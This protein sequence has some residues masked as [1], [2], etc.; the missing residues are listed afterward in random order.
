MAKTAMVT[1]ASGGIGLEFAERLAKEGYQ[2]TLVARG[3]GKLKEIVA[4]LGAGHR[5]IAADL[6]VAADTRRVA[7]DVRA[8]KYDL[9]VNN[10]GVGVYGWF[11]DVPVEPT[12]AMMRLN[13][14]SLV[15]LSHTFLQGAKSGDALL[16]VAST[17]AL[18]SFPGAATYCA[19]K[20]FVTA[21]S[22]GLWFENKPRGVYVAALLPGVTKTN[23]H[24]ASGGTADQTPPAAITQTSAQVV[25]VAMAALESR[26]SPT[27][28]TSFTNKAMVF[29][30]TRIIPRKAMVNLMGGQSPVKR[31][32]AQ[33]KA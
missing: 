27:I 10:A 9:L 30:S 15:E 24:E 12:L 20:A 29:F 18:L 14:D 4:R 21:F 7:D 28:L 25:D 31:A 23:F 6:S 32:P 17:L 13:M 1:G 3:E 8:T 33:L 19:T 22:E 26:S 16:N 11:A 5:S 2:V